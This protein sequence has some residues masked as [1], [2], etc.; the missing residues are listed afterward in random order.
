M[1]MVLA[2]LVPLIALELGEPFPRYVAVFL[3]KVNLALG[4]I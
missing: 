2:L 3:Y 4:L 1:F